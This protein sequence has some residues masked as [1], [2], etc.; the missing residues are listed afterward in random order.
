MLHNDSIDARFAISHTEMNT[1]FRDSGSASSSA[2]SNKNNQKETYEDQ[3]S[4]NHGEI[5]ADPGMNFRNSTQNERNSGGIWGFENLVKSLGSKS[6]GIIKIYRRDLEEFGTGLMKETETLKNLAS[7]AVK[8]L[9]K[10][11]TIHTEEGGLRVSNSSTVSNSSGGKNAEQPRVREGSPLNIGESSVKVSNYSKS[12]R[13]KNNA[14]DENGWGDAAE[15]SSGVDPV[16]KHSA[17]ANSQ[18]QGSRVV[19]IRR[20]MSVAA[21]DDEDLSWDL[22]EDGGDAKSAENH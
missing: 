19:D 9:Q 18:V 15:D 20:I 4:P 8:S 12:D 6:E 7:R 21:E 10:E 16:N 2:N 3:K 11:E 22:D 14:E 13:V 1:F 17:A 5:G